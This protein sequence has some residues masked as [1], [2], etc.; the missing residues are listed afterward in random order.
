M[1]KNAN[2]W[3]IVGNRIGSKHFLAYF[4]SLWIKSFALHM[5]KFTKNGQFTVKVM[6]SWKSGHYGPFLEKRHTEYFL[7][8][9]FGMSL[10]CPE[11]PHH[12]LCSFWKN[13]LKKSPCIVV[14]FG[15]P[16]NSHE[17]I[18]RIRKWNLAKL[19]MLFGF[20]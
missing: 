20:D 8:C 15:G 1:V 13:L 19:C 16:N 12:L 3:L 4:Q 11:I 6:A 5:Q 14:E 17:I 7:I 2:F 9:H 10:V 18:S